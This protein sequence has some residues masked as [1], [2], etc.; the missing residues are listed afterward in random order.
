M[1]FLR[2]EKFDYTGIEL[3]RRIFFFPRAKFVICKGRLDYCDMIDS[4]K[5]FAR[6][7]NDQDEV[8]ISAGMGLVGLR[9]ISPSTN[10]FVINLAGIGQFYLEIIQEPELL[11]PLTDSL[12]RESSILTAMEICGGIKTR[13]ARAP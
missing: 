12:D 6:P 1:P 8:L 13:D 4:T 11:G 9:G 5:N 7:L 2:I 10:C 3:V